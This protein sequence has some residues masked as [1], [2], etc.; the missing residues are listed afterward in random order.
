MKKTFGLIIL[1]LGLNSCQGQLTEKSN[2]NVSLKP[3]TDTTFSFES[4][5]VG[6]LPYGWSNQVGKWSIAGDNG[7][8]VLYQSASSSGGTFN[9]AVY[10]GAVYAD[11][12]MSVRIKAI[13]G[14]GDQGGGMVW[15]FI[16]KNN[17]YIVRE[18][19]LED[20]VVLYKVENGTRKD[21]PI[22]GKGRTYGAPVDKLGNGWNNLKVIVKGELFV[23][24]LNG[25]EIFQVKDT[26]FT[27]PGRIGVWSKAD[28]ASYFDDLNVHVL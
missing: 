26:T 6:K 17:Y 13:S 4:G 10:D 25:K 19:P 14:D 12:E 20:N 18:N 22:V 21:L 3:G 9:I 16:D 28:A 1:A 11:V 8:K 24:Y 23:V 5:E 2:F 15:R 27:Q 7:N